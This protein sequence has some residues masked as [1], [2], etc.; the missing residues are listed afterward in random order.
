M[1]NGGHLVMKRTRAIAIICLGIMILLAFCLVI[2]DIFVSNNTNND[3]S[4][5]ID[6]TMSEE[7]VE[8]SIVESEETGEI[9][10]ITDSV[11]E[12]E[13]SCDVTGE[14]EETSEE[15]DKHLSG[16]DMPDIITDLN[17]NIYNYTSTGYNTE[18]AMV[19]LNDIQS[20][21]LIYAPEGM[22]IS[23]AMA[24]AYT[25]GG[26]GK[27]NSI[28]SRTNN[29]F[30]I[31]AGPGW[32]GYVYSRNTGRVYKNYE[33]AKNYGEKN[34][35]RGGGPNLF[36]AYHCMEDSVKDYVELI[37][38]EY[39]AGALDIDSP[40]AYLQYLVNRNYGGQSMYYVWIN[41]MNRFKLKE[42]EIRDF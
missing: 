34:Q 1:I 24:Q 8:P 32:A 13:T 39:Y 41:V 3:T 38:S 4:S 12:E 7:G 40:E 10:E 37:C 2:N 14:S 15:N 36:R 6:N 30:G 22:W 5:S 9:T 26:A 33:V 17:V 35:S 27:N 11:T 28:Y 20:C 18:D 25:E 29:C 31:T 16:L 23:A 42:F 19:Y 21:L